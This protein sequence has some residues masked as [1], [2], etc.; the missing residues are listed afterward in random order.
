MSITLLTLDERF[1]QMV[2][3]WIQVDTTTNITTNNSLIS[4]ALQNYDHGVDDRFENYWV[5]LEENNNSAVERLVYD[6]YTS[7]GTCLLR[8]ANLS[9][10]SSATTF[11]LTKTKFTDRKTAINDALRELYSYNVLRK[12][13]DNKTLISGNI[14]PNSH[15]EDWASSS[16]PDKYGVTNA[17]AAATTTAGLYRG[18]AKSSKVTASAAD[19]Y[20][21]ITS[22]DYPE[23]LDLRGE[24]IDFK[25]W[26][27]PEVSDDAFL[28]I[29][30]T[31]P[32]GTAQ[33]LNSTTAVYAGKWNLIELES[34]TIN[35]DINYIEFRFR[36][37]TNAKYAY[38]DDARVVG[39]TVY[40]Y[41]LPGDFQDGDIRTVSIQYTGNSDDICDD[42]GMVKYGA[43]YNWHTVDN[44]TDKFLHI[45]S[46]PKGYRI[47]LEGETPFDALTAATSTVNITDEQAN[48][49]LEYAIF[50]L[51]RRLAG[52]MTSDDTAKIYEKAME[53]YSRYNLL[54][55]RKPRKSGRVACEPL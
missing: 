23:L 4:T 13:V 35:D 6:Y 1:C 53:H 7:T 18:G 22:N 48:V 42:I 11:R 20:M 50:L 16:Y 55:G 46:A 39:K 31:E 17:T 3:D 33:T 12:G 43:I 52:L 54:S 37:H 40:D 41:L 49:L 26:V 38:F 47:K 27:Y 29:Y 45:D 51:Y 25:A 8:G 10:D 44:G 19:G 36:V 28:T 34:Q 24:T 21:S 30:T 14:L 5:Y 9:A 32:D 15:F 2:G